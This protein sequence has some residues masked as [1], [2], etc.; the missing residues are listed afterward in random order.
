MAEVQ[1]S[2]EQIMITDGPT[3]QQLAESLF[4]GPGSY[5]LFVVNG[6]NI[7]ARITAMRVASAEEE[8]EANQS[9]HKLIIEGYCL[10]RWPSFRWLY[11]TQTRQGENAPA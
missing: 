1:S 9:C 11:N 7:L 8:S 4:G 6:H 2:V 5:V 10:V 3:G